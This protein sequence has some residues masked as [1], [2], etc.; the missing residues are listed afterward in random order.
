MEE[1]TDKELMKLVTQRNKM[2]FK[3]LY[4]R[5]ELLIFNFVLRCTGSRE[6]AQDLLQEAFTRVWIAAHTFD[7][8]RGAFKSWLFRI[9]LN[10]T[11]NE[12]SKKQYNFYFVDI[13][14]HP[15]RS[16]DAEQPEKKWEESQLRDR[17]AHA[18]GKLKPFL[19]EVIIMRYYH[20]LK[21]REI[22]HITDIPEGT[23]KTRFHRAIAMLRTHLKNLEL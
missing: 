7:P 10:M 17:I 5:Y 12:M 22:A 13:E 11:R 4:K 1:Q 2:A 20:Q 15:F 16:P 3:I 19:R 21:F 8:K 14:E 6:I 9:A 18:I 23:L